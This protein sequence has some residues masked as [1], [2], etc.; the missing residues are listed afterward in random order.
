[1]IN[2]QQCL[3]GY[4]RGHRLLASSVELPHAQADAMLDLTDLSGPREAVGFE[5]YLTGYPLVGTEYYVLAKTWLAYEMSRPG[6]VWTHSLLVSKG[7][8][9]DVSATSLN[10]AFR[11]PNVGDYARYKSPIELVPSE[12][13]SSGSAPFASKVLAA[14]YLSAFSVWLPWSD[15]SSC[16]SAIL[17]LWD[18]QWPSLRSAFAFSTGSFSPRQVNGRPLDLQVLPVTQLAAWSRQEHATNALEMA[19]LP[20]SKRAAHDLE[21]PGRLRRFLWE[22]GVGGRERYALL[23]EAV[24]ATEQGDLISGFRTLDMANLSSSRLARAKR[25]LLQIAPDLEDADLLRLIVQD[26]LGSS[27][28]PGGRRISTVVK[29]LLETEPSVA[30]RLAQQAIERPESPGAQRFLQSLAASFAVSDLP[31]MRDSDLPIFLALL[32]SRPSLAAA[33]ALWMTSADVQQMIVGTIRPSTRD[34]EKITRAIVQAGSD[35][36]FVWAANAWPAHVV[37]AVLDAA[38][39]GRLNPG[40]RDAATRLAAR[41]PSEVLQWARGRAAPGAGSLEFVADSSTI[42]TAMHFAAVDS[43]LQWAVDESPKSDR[44]WG[45]LFGLALN[46]RGE[47]ARALLAHSFR[48]LH[49]LAARSWL[50]DRSWS[51]IDDQVP[52]IGVFWDWDRCERLRRAVTSKF[53]EEKWDPAGLVDFAY[54][55]EVDRDLTA[56]FREVKS[57]REFLKK[58]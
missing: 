20:W 28:L 7:A 24:T 41:H 22:A 57:G 9:A 11:R 12:R 55:S 2:L 15:S 10:L 8:L 52:H 6:C 46:W 23:V 26:E 33:P 42:S 1:V 30:I 48:R 16:E 44:A 17:A 13:W 5:A 27:P 49:D 58:R 39:A 19:E 53:V 4:E 29:H 21:S 40:I 37:R 18:Q 36:G 14:L 32:R 34:A 54:S 38:E 45:L 25:A 56:A 3:H 35:P 43:W 31:Y 47:A 51:L 50:S